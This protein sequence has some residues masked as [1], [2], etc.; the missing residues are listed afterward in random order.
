MFIVKTPETHESELGK[1]GGET[2]VICASCDFQ[3]GS[4]GLTSVGEGPPT[5]H[6]LY[7]VSVFQGQSGYSP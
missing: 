5:N 1:K 7:K 3:R 6:K 2:S 4:R